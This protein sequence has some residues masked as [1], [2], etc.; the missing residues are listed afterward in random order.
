MEINTKEI[1]LVKQQVSKAELAVNAVVVK[2]DASM[3]EAG[4][5]RSK[6]KAVGK[7]IKEKKESITKPLN[8]ALKQVRAMFAPIEA[9]YENVESIISGKMIE[10]QN[11][12][13]AEKRKVEAEA[14]KKLE[15]TKKKLEDGKL[16][17][18]QVEKIEAKLETK[19]EQ[20][21]QVIRSSESFHTREIQKFRI[22]NEL[23]IPRE[24][25]VP[26][27]VKIRA[28]MMNGVPVKGVEYYKKKSLV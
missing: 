9:D 5:I 1:E 11:K 28:A 20:A 10:F 3:L 24:Y 25:L 14:L 17:E 2:D 23:E 7:M 4:E 15:E 18:K 8:E 19:L 21:P 27:E 26:D 12:V 6:I 16:T 13:E 22:V